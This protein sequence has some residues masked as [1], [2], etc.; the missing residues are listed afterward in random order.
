VFPEHRAQLPILPE[1][2]DVDA[3]HISLK[4]EL[5]QPDG[6]VGMLRTYRC[7]HCG[8]TITYGDRHPPGAI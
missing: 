3:F 7:K 4:L 8:E 1:P 6:L 2:A 5:T